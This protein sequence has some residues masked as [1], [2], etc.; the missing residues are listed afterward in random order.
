MSTEENIVILPEPR[1]GLWQEGERATF[2]YSLD[3]DAASSIAARLFPR[4]GSVVVVGG[5]CDDFAD[6]DPE[7]STLAQRA[8]AGALRV[9]SIRFEDGHEDS[10]FEDELSE[11]P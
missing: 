6:A 3:N 11:T 10:A 2:T 1:D 5:R 4:S 7:L 9:Y 8:D